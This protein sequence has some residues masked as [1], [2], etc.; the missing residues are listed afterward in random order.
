MTGW[1]VDD[2]EVVRV[3]IHRDPVAGE[4]A[5]ILPFVGDAT[6]VEGA[7]PDVQAVVH[8]HAPQATILVNADLPFLP[9]STEAAFL[10]EIGRLVESAGF[11]ARLRRVTVALGAD[12]VPGGEG[13]NADITSGGLWRPRR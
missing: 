5:G 10:A 11:P 13:N 1:A 12:G 3:R 4:P 2:I 9:I 8:C 6:R 7:R